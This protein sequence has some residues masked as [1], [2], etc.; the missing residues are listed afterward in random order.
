MTVTKPFLLILGQLGSV[1]RSESWPGLP[2][3]T[4]RRRRLKVVEVEVSGGAVEE[5][6]AGDELVSP[7]LQDL[8]VRYRVLRPQ[9][10]PL[11]SISH[12]ARTLV[13]THKRSVRP[14][15]Q[16]FFMNVEYNHVA[17]QYVLNTRPK[18]QNQV[19]IHRGFASVGYAYLK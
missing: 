19:V 4:R 9:S 2:W 17:F 16:A 15:S 18:S 14:Y 3:G 6:A 1:S 7:K 12:K 8:P 10:K 5:E 13:F 11:L